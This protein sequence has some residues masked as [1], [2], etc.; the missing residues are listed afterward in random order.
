M[1]CRCINAYLIMIL[2]Y[3]DYFSY[4]LILS[5]FIIVSPIKT[6]AM[7]LRITL[8]ILNI[9]KYILITTLVIYVKRVIKTTRLQCTRP[10]AKTTQL[11][12]ANTILSPRGKHLR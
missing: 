4:K 5:P 12:I 10:M 6:C 7:K 8:L 3:S 11:P 2:S 9:N 1:P